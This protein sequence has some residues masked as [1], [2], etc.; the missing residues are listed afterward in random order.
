MTETATSVPVSLPFGP[1]TGLNYVVND[2]FL[3]VGFQ[4]DNGKAIVLSEWAKRT[5]NNAPLLNLPLLRSNQWYVAGGWR[6]GKLTPLLIYGTLNEGSS[7]LTPAQSSAT[8]SASLRYDIVRNVALKA[9]FSNPQALNVAYWTAPNYASNER[10]NV[11][12]VGADFV[13]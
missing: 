6:F 12:S 3:S 4:Y 8:W 1:P 10:V 13:F 11:I 2:K 9:Q 5:Q 7:L